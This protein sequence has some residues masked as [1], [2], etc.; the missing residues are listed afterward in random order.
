[1]GTGSFPK[2]KRPGRG[3]DHPPP[4]NAEVKERVDLY[5][6]STQWAFVA[7]SRVNITFT[8][9]VFSVYYWAVQKLE[10]GE[11]NI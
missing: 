2:L 3:F 7:C 5:L 1:M 8:F 6:Y 9:S 4:F 11:G 10:N